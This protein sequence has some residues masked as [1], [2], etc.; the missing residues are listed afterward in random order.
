M[1]HVPGEAF[2][3]WTASVAI[4]PDDRYPGAGCIAY[5]PY[6][7]ISRFWVVP[8][9]ADDSVPAFVAHLLDGLEPWT[10]CYVWFRGG[11]WPDLANP[12]DSD[13]EV[14]AVTFR[15]A[16]IRSRFEGAIQFDRSERD[17][18]LAVLFVQLTFGWHSWDDLFVIPDHGRMMLMTDHHG[19][20]H[21]NFASRSLVRP[22]V[23]H[24][25]A[26]GFALPTEVPD[27]TFG[28][29]RRWMRPR[30]SNLE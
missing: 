4:G 15:G 24:M 25:A 1:Q 10:T 8:R 6:R 26:G 11:R 13:A 12:L 14:R 21:A 22:F 19:V 23:K 5:R 18:I 27:W 29:R 28:P 9:S 20:V 2:L 3:D 16:R 30:R 17:R 7:D